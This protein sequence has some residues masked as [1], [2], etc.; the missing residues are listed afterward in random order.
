[1]LGFRGIE[2]ALLGDEGYFKALSENCEIYFWLRHVYLF[3]SSSVGPSAWI[4][5]A[6][7]G[8]ICVKFDI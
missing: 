7:T 5:S 6:P 4:N 8:Q 2:V 1:M 3:L